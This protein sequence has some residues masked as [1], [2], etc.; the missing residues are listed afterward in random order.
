MI[1]ATLSD[2]PAVSNDGIKDDAVAVA[3]LKMIAAR[4]SPGAISESNSSH[5]PPS[6]ASKAAKP[7]A[8]PPG[9]SSRATMLL[10]TGSLRF[11]KTIGIVRVSRSGGQRS[12]RP[13]CQNDVGL[14]ADQLSRE[15]SYPI[16][17]TAAPAKVHHHV[18]AIGPARIRKR[19]SER[20]DA[21][22]IH[23]IVF[24]APHSKGPPRNKVGE[25]P[26]CV[27]FPTL[28][29]RTLPFRAKSCWLICLLFASEQSELHAYA[30][31]QIWAHFAFRGT[32][33]R[34]LDI[35]L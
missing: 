2:R 13:V 6:E 3:G 19:L 14:Q 30:S 15:G 4:F 20:R 11:P 12:A 34:G 17:V 33:S 10:A 29:C 18:A 21:R 23:G 27:R 8:F 31:R 22:L 25:R 5:L 35:S 9:R 26:T 7:V 1:G 16:G 32:A 28:L 24:V